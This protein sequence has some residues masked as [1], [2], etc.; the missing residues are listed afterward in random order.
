[1][2][3]TQHDNDK[4]KVASAYDRSFKL[5]QQLMAYEWYSNFINDLEPLQIAKFN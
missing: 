5:E 4:G 2:F 1:M 3:S